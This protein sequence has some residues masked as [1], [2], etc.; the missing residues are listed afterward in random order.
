MEHGC[1]DN[2]AKSLI[3]FLSLILMKREN[4]CLSRYD[5]LKK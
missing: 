1:G 3:A 5:D 2:F 4:M